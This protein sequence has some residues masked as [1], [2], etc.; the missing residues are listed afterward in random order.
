MIKQQVFLDANLALPKL[1]KMLSWSPPKLSQL[2]NDNLHQSFNDFVNSYRIAH[3][4]T[5]LL[6]DSVMKME[7]LAERSGF[8]SLSTFYTAFKKHT[9]LT[10][11]KYK[12]LQPL[13]NSET[14]N[15]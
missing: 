3:A 13:G 15:P 9:Q 2:L 7:D 11:A 4:K 1:A 6:G 14:I 10:P 12:A 8:N 5:L